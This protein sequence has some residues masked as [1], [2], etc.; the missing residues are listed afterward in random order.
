MRA[1]KSEVNGVGGSELLSV[2]MRPD[3]SRPELDESVGQMVTMHAGGGDVTVL[4]LAPKRAFEVDVGG[5]RTSLTM[6]T[7]VVEGE[8]YDWFEHWDR[9]M[10]WRP[11]GGPP[12]DKR[13]EAALLGAL[14]RRLAPSVRRGNPEAV[15]ALCCDVFGEHFHE[16]DELQGNEDGYE[17]QL[18]DDGDDVSVALTRPVDASELKKLLEQVPEDWR[19]ALLRAV[20]CKAQ[21]GNGG[22]DVEGGR[23]RPRKCRA[24]YWIGGALALGLTGLLT[25]YCFLNNQGANQQSSEPGCPQFRFGDLRTTVISTN[26]SGTA[27][28][29][30]APCD[31]GTLFCGNKQNASMIDFCRNFGRPWSELFSQAWNISQRLGFEECGVVCHTPQETR[32]AIAT[33]LLERFPLQGLNTSIPNLPRADRGDVPTLLG[34]EQIQ[35]IFAA[36]IRDPDCS[37]SVSP[38]RELDKLGRCFCDHANITCDVYSESLTTATTE[39]TRTTEYLTYY[40]YLP[41]E[42]EEDQKVEK[43]GVPNDAWTTAFGVSTYLPDLSASFAPYV[44]QGYKVGCCSHECSLISP[45]AEK[46]VRANELQ[47]RR[48]ISVLGMAKKVAWFNGAFDRGQAGLG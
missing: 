38:W 15:D 3:T 8:S 1:F 20:A 4:V 29:P 31:S 14:R 26:R 30:V 42:K 23:A 47:V 24:E 10:V 18:L 27:P 11:K 32:S 36:F 25:G 7:A 22:G 45:D 28:M 48:A 2:L 34:E 12:S 35:P 9:M 43:C 5:E 19:P 37:G 13:A 16:L 46:I 6:E 41:K 33:R 40:F 21:D 44:E 39:T 17:M